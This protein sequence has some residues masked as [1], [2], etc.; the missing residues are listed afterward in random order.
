MTA[1]ATMA[2]NG[3]LSLIAIAN[4]QFNHKRYNSNYL[5]GKYDFNKEAEQRE[6]PNKDEPKPKRRNFSVLINPA[7]ENH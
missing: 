6:E 4:K 5:Q 1:F 7:F 2:A 3:S